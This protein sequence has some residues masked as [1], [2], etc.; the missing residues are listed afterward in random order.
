MSRTVKL[1]ISGRV[2]GVYFRKFTQHKAK[3]LTITG[4]VK[5]LDDGRVEIIAQADETNLD[6]FIKWC[7]KGPIMARVDKVEIIELKIDIDQYN[8]FKII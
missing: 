2:Q 6:L 7:H 8:M 5:N 1:I 3:E 4:T